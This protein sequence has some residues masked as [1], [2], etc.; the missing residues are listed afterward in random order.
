MKQIEETPKEKSIALAVIQDD[1]GFDW[2]EFLQE[3]DAKLHPSKDVGITYEGKIYA[4]WKEAKR[5]NRWDPDHLCYLDPKGN[6]IVEQKN[7]EKDEAKKA[8]EERLKSMNVD[9]G[10]IDTTKGMTAEN[11]IK[12]SDKVL[13]AKALEVDSKSTSSSEST[14]KVNNSVST[15][16]SGKTDSAKTE[17]DCRNCMKECK[18]CSTHAYL[19]LKKTHDLVEKV[20]LVE[21][22]VLEINCLELQM[23]ESKN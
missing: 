1:D 5:A 9:N 16:E 22:Q 23:K 10:I 20:E 14:S 12:M 18:V 4:A 7:I 21:K 2:S 6:I 17:S 8:E 19:S 11:L 15:N 3:D 13:M